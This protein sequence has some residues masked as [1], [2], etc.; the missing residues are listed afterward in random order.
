MD[1]SRNILIIFLFALVF[2]L[3]HILASLLIPLVLAMLFAIVFQPLV[4]MFKKWKLPDWLVFPTV[5]IITLGVLFVLFDIV[6]QTSYD[7]ASQK[8]YL[9][10]RLTTKIE[11]IFAWFE[12]MEY[13]NTEAESVSELIQGLINGEFISNA[14]GDIASSVGS[15]AG[16]FFMFALYY[17]TILSG[18]A[19]NRQFVE[20]LGGDK[21]QALSENYEKVIKSVN[22]YVVVKTIISL[23]TSVLVM[24]VCFSFG[25]KFPI[26]W[27]FMTFILNFIPSIG[28]IIATVPPVI[29]AIIQ[30]DSFN[31]I[32]ILLII[33][34]AIQSIMGNLVEPKV[35]GERLRLNTITVI[36]GLV[37]W[38]YIWGIPGMML[39][40]PLMVILKLIFEH[41]PSMNIL[42][43]LMGYPDKEMKSEELKVN[44]EQ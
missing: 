9:A 26:F 12:G 7:I 19:K 13:I 15:F 27:G 3:L 31:T 35:M 33:L 36:F 24:I 43:R 22:S 38:G 28:S 30:F 5:S 23:I 29:M 17:I 40:V 21:T 18:L 6:L 20:Y 14:A 4:R 34:I 1:K 42:A 11:N 39:S 37:F 16:S 10:E 2:Y 44:N 8:D 41:I 32:L 25:I